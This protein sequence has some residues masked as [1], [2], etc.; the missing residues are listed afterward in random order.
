ME[1]KPRTINNIDAEFAHSFALVFGFIDL[2]AMLGS[3]VD[4]LDKNTIQGIGLA[5]FLE[6]QKVQELYSEMSRLVP[7]NGEADVRNLK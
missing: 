2:I 7:Y 4:E 5:C 6:A 3:R 1:N